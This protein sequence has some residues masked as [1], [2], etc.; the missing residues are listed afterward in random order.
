MKKIRLNTRFLVNEG[1]PEIMTLGVAL[2]IVCVFVNDWIHGVISTIFSAIVFGLSAWSVC[3]REYSEVK[4][5][6]SKLHFTVFEL[7]F[8]AMMLG[9]AKLYA[10]S[11]QGTMVQLSFGFIVIAQFLLIGWTY[12]NAI[13]CEQENDEYR[14]RAGYHALWIF[15]MFFI[16]YAIFW[17]IIYFGATH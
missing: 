13:H 17:G 6:V 2:Y 10:M 4:G 9:F 14:K 11:E 12:N 7:S 15:A 1:I 16:L 5:K 8:L 3:S